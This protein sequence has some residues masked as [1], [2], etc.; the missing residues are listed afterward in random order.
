MNYKGNLKD[1][2]NNWQ[3]AAL[4]GITKR[5]SIKKGKLKS[6][7]LQ[8]LYDFLNRQHVPVTQQVLFRIGREF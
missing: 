1:N 5:I 8:L 6:T 4:L 2:F 3:K 7:N